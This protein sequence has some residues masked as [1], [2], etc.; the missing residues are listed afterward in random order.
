MDIKSDKD[1]I[2][3]PIRD[4]RSDLHRVA[5]PR[6]LIEADHIVNLPILKSHC[7]MLFTCALKNIKGTVQDKV[8]WQM[9][10]MNLAASMM[11][12]SVVKADITIADLIRPARATDPT[13]RCP[14]TLVASLR[15]LILWRST[16]RSAG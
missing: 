7:S 10:Q 2:S 3:V 11:V 14:S 8:H 12:W 5:L 1:L 6:F 4:A 16:P 9:H 13:R 15:A